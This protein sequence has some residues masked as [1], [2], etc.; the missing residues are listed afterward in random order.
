MRIPSA[1][2]F[3]VVGYAAV[4][5]RQ[6]YAV[7]LRKILAFDRCSFHPSLTSRPVV[8]LAA[9]SV[10]GDDG[11]DTTATAPVD[12]NTA[13]KAKSATPLSRKQVAAMMEVSFV[14]GVMQLAT[15]HVET[16][17]L[18][19]AAVL[20]AYGSLRIPLDECL[21]AVAACPTQTANRPLLP[22]E[23]ALRATW[24]KLVY[25][26]ASE[27]QYRHAIVQ[28]ASLF[29]PPSAKDD[30]DDDNDLDVYRQ[31][32]PRLRQKHA[33]GNDAGPRFRAQEIWEQN[34]DILAS[35]SLSS[36]AI[37]ENNNGDDMAKALLL[38]NLRLM[39]IT[40]TVLE[41]E[42]LCLDNGDPEPPAPPIPNKLKR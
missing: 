7:P 18:F 33:Q 3:P 4:P 42:K 9:A 20:T 35:S 12:D 6:Q 39:W 21:A 10:N 19:I 36:A 27:V 25:L 17:K 41:E 31:M 30:D 13:K 32:L 14:E 26:I 15:G 40:L 38:Q 34:D 8:S 22:E 24:I 37:D 2:G 16:V 29:V 5:R 28:G 11:D 1:L 23:E